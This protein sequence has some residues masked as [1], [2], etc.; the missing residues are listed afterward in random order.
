MLPLNYLRQVTIGIYQIQL[1]PS[2]IQDKLQKEEAEEFQVE[3]LRDADRIPRPEFMRV[4][5]YSR[6][7]NATKYQLWI[8]YM[9]NNDDEVDDGMDNDEVNP[10]QGYY[11]TCKSG[12]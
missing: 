3:M 1:A 12:A 4:R 5:V 9:P 6:F 8:A 10:V 2:Y 7:R 11:C